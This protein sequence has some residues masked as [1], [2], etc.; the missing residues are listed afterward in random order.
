MEETLV[1]MRYA[2]GAIGLTGWGYIM[3]VSIAF[4]AGIMSGD[5]K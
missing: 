3:L 5:S 4:W 1:I 2:D